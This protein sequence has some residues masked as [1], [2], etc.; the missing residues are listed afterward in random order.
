MRILLVLVISFLT[1]F[2]IG[3]LL[4]RLFKKPIHNFLGL[5]ILILGI[6]LGLFGK[7]YFPNPLDIL[8]S[9]T[10]IG[11]GLGLLTH[12]LLRKQY[13]IHERLEKNFVTRHETKFERF[14][15]SLPGILTWIAL[16]SPI[17]LSFTLPF[18]VAYIILIAQIYWFISS[19]RIA[20]LII[21]GF[22]KFEFARRQEWLKK[23]DQDFKGDWE[24][25]YHL[26]V[27]PVYKESLEVLKPDFDAILNANYPKDKIILAV[28]F[29]ERVNPKEH[30]KET[31]KYLE[32]LKDKLGDVFISFHPANLPGEV[33]GP[34]T[35]RNWM[36]KEAVKK[37]K[38]KKIK[39]EDVIVT[40]LDCDF[41]ID[42]EYIGGM[43]YRYL[44]TPETERLK[45]SYTGV[46]LYYNNYWQAPTPTRLI[47][48]G[49]SFWQL[50]EMVGSDKYQNYSSM[51]INLKPL[52]DIGGWIPDKIND[53]SGFYWKAYFH[54][55]GD[56]KVIPHYM[57]IS[58]DTVLDVNLIKTLQ[59]QYLQLKRWAYGVEHIPYIFKQYFKNSDINF[60][61]K[62]D[63]LLFVLWA[64][65]RWGFLAL[66]VTFAG[67]I[68]PF[69]NP[70]YSQSV[71]AINL[72]I[73]SSWILTAAFLGLFATIYVHEKTV[74]PRPKNWSK[75]RKLWSYLQHLLVPI[76]LVTIS[77]LPA[78]D[79]QT[80][81]LFGKHL[82]F[83]TTN[84]AR[85]KVT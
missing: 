29:E 63:K 1:S 54:F 45:R 68:I 27:V 74:P 10:L 6:I 51:S 55:K 48:T 17:W 35:N 24:K 4:E 33:P 70:Q 41:V 12:H 19:I 23:L 72:P 46:F 69:V 76:V 11:S 38:D 77:T 83:R 85:A 42:K 56:Y 5:L 81:L 44:Q 62:T 28:G 32:S 73:I 52:L 2:F 50:A 9:I 78:I 61:D 47:A 26:F 67:I 31:I 34:G 30:H 80:S 37:L 7:A 82:E 40:T 36:I 60:W 3:E 14:L 75:V 59:N 71:V 66:F 57:P 22:K 65:M 21:L 49:T 43:M 79:A 8:I 84:K 58:A 18:A 64:N 13:L 15:E 20:S 39:T 53:D 25:Y 16:T